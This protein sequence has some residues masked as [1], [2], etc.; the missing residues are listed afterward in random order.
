MSNDRLE[1]LIGEL[2]KE[3]EDHPLSGDERDLLRS[4]LGNI[5]DHLGAD[6]MPMVPSAVDTIHEMERQWAEQH[7]ALA[8][9]LRRLIDILNQSGI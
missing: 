5:L 8:T 1:H 6:D 3:L 2:H 9:G 7:P 4:A